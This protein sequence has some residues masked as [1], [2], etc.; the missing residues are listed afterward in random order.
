MYSGDSGRRDRHSSR[1]LEQA[2]PENPL[3]F[4]LEGEAQLVEDL[5]RRLAIKY[6]MIDAWKRG[7]K[8]EDEAVS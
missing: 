2:Q 1:D 8:P 4:L 3:G 6:G 7:K 5:L